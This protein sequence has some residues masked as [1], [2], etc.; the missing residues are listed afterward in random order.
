MAA[1]IELKSAQIKSK[2]FIASIKPIIYP[3][4]HKGIQ[5]T[6]FAWYLYRHLEWGFGADNRTDILSDIERL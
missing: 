6:R 2:K 4:D 5:Q 1:L 3:L